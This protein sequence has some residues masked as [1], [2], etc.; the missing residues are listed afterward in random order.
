[1][2]KIKIVIKY[3]KTPVVVKLNYTLWPTSLQLG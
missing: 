1:M 3:E 2:A